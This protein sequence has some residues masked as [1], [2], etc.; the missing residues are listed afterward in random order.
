[1]SIFADQ[2]IKFC[3]SSREQS[4]ANYLPFLQYFS[5][6]I[7]K[8]YSFY[9]L[10]WLQA[11]F[12]NFTRSWFDV[13]LFRRINFSSDIYWQTLKKNPLWKNTFTKENCFGQL[14]HSYHFWVG[15]K[16]FTTRISAFLH[17][18]SIPHWRARST[19]TS[20]LRLIT[21]TN[22]A[23]FLC[24]IRRF[25]GRLIWNSTVKSLKS[26]RRGASERF[27]ATTVRVGRGSTMRG[28]TCQV[29]M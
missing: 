21:A 24:R 9:L 26:P 17:S 7:V 12:L 4:P 25:Q 13:I 8:S 23:A 18:I 2:N 10:L 15:R 19:A 28:F 16:T 11:L 6:N 3:N 27:W 1:M 14:W 5:K 29:L 22:G 20:A